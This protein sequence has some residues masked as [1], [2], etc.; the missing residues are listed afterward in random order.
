MNFSL[1]SL[2][3]AS[4]KI[5]DIGAASLANVLEINSTLNTMD[6]SLNYIGDEGGM[7]L[8]N[9]MNCNQTLTSLKYEYSEKKWVVQKNQSLYALLLQFLSLI[10]I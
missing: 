3:L 7:R 4:N 1:L 6:I 8:R 10:H 9:A 5:T 2:T